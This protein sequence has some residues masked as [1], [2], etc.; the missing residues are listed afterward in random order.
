[1][2]LI[3]WSQ[4]AVFNL[5]SA[6]STHSNTLA[7][8]VHRFPSW[9]LDPS[10]NT[11]KKKNKEKIRC[12]TTAHAWDHEVQCS[13]SVK[14][15]AGVDIFFTVSEKDNTIWSCNKCSVSSYGIWNHQF[16]Y[17]ILTLTLPVSDRSS[18][19]SSVSAQKSTYHASLM[20][21]DFAILPGLRCSISLSLSLSKC[22]IVGDWTFQF[23]E[24]VSPLIRCASSV[25]L[26]LGWEVKL[27]HVQ[28]PKIQ[29]RQNNHDMHDWEPS[30]T[31]I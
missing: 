11:K 5:K 29:H 28:A 16:A 1:M 3:K 2:E 14:H 17:Y 30:S 4:I 26:L 12:Q 20:G 10:I 15:V 18:R 21:A 7:A 6:A 22:F 27:K 9:L 31:C 24:D 13:V 19:Y 23:L 25:L 8:G